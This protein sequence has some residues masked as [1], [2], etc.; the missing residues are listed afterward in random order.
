VVSGLDQPPASDLNINE[1]NPEGTLAPGVAIRVYD[2][3]D[4]AGVIP[5]DF[6]CVL[7]TA[8]GWSGFHIETILR[9]VGVFERRIGPKERRSN[10]AK[11][12]A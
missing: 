8:A 5:P 3:S 1:V 6:E 2:A 9:V 11:N 10:K 12:S 4:A 7:Q